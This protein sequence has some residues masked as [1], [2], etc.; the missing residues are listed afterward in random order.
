MLVEQ[1]APDAVPAPA[2]PDLQLI[3]LVGREPELEASRRNGEPASAR[4]AAWFCQGP[5]WAKRAWL[6]KR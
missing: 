4:M 6:R 3:P 5:G 1:V 2:A